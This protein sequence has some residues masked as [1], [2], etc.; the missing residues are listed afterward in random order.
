MMNLRS[1]SRELK[2]ANV[3]RITLAKSVLATIPYY[4]QSTMLPKTTCK[5]IEMII[6]HFLWGKSEDKRGITLVRWNTVCSLIPNDGLVF[7]ILEKQNDAFLMKISFNLVTCPNQL[8]AQVLRT[9]YRWKETVPQDIAKPSCT[10]L[11]KGISLVWENVRDSLVWSIGNDSSIDFRR[12]PWL[13]DI[14]ASKDHF[15]I[16]ERFRNLPKVTIDKMV[17]GQG[18]WKW[19]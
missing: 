10:R 11:W 14:G 7:K 2:P 8:W 3:G 16:Q 6:R 1:F 19:C 15:N 4:M 18:E 9:K 13:G 12:G 17:N 5:E